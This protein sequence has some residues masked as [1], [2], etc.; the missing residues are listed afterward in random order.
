MEHSTHDH[1]PV[2]LSVIIVAYYSRELID[3]CI[4]SVWQYNDLGPEELEILVVE[5]SPEEEANAMREYLNENYGKGVRLLVNDGNR[6]YGSGNNLGISNSQGSIV[7]VMNPDI[8]LTEPLFGDALARFGADTELGVLG[9]KQKGNRDISFYL[10]PELYFPVF[11]TVVEIATNRLNIYLQKYFYLSGAF[12]LF[13]K[14]KFTAAGS[15]DESIFLYFEEPDIIRRMHALNYRVQ[16]CKQKSYMH[17]ID[18]RIGFSVRA[19][20]VLISSLRYYLNK[21]GFKEDWVI[22]RM[23]MEYKLKR[24]IARLTGRTEL[25]K[26]M[27]ETIAVVDESRN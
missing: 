17:L 5:N 21:H 26:L 12:M 3:D 19:F 18:G 20:R 9:Y 14:E 8:R 15:Y 27:N 23:R 1:N 6:G 13:N 11:R 7:A 4:R 2:K 24:T 16:Y 10:N 25:F 22:K